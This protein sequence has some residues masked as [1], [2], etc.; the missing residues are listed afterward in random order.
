[1]S[2]RPF[3]SFIL[4]AS[5]SLAACGVGHDD[6]DP[7]VTE[8]TTDQ[9]IIDAEQR[10]APTARPDVTVSAN[11]PGLEVR[12]LFG[13]VIGIRGR[14]SNGGIVGTRV[15]VKVDTNGFYSVP[16]SAGD[17][18][19]VVAWRIRAALSPS[20]ETLVRLGEYGNAYVIVRYTGLA[21]PR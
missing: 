20:F 7:S 10:I 17:G 6:T 4:A 1:M 13:N 3:Q 12:S 16:V 14:V 11:A 2:F 18:P 8:P 9:S 19:L 5:L 21:Q 15:T